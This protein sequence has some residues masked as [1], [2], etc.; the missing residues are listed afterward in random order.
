MGKS[1]FWFRYVIFQMVVK[2]SGRDVKES[3]N[4]KEGV[5]WR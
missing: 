2:Y 5:G 1:E 4:Y 3:G